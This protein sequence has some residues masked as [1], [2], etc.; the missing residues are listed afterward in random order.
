MSSW[1]NKNIVRKTS[2]IPTLSYIDNPIPNNPI[3]NSETKYIKYISGG[4]MGDFLFQLSVICE[5]YHKTGKKGILYISNTVGDEFRFGLEDTYRK[6]KQLVEYQYYIQEYSIHNN[7]N[8]DINLSIWRNSS[9]I[10]KTNWVDLFSSVYNIKWGNN[11]WL[12]IPKD[13]KFEDKIVITHSIN[14]YNTIDRYYNYFNDIDKSKIVF[15]YLCEE[16]LSKFIEKTGLNYDSHKC[17]DFYELAII[18]NSCQFHVSNCSSPLSISL[19]IKKQVYIFLTPYEHE[20]IL[21]KD[22]NGTFNISII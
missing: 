13:S 5:M 8:Y 16:D 6:T 15:V 7:E 11:I 19:A 12:N 21:F 1:L 10:W 20:Q 2:K 14:R 18:I 17:N 9:T 4:L 22:L 3:P